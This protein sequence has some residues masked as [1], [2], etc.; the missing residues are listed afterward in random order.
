MPPISVGPRLDRERVTGP[1]CC[2]H[3][4]PGESWYVWL[5]GDSGGFTAPRLD[6]V[7]QV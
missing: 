2:R 6:R 5:A 4:G 3:D 7:R 1:Q